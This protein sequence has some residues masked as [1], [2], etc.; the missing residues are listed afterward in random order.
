[1]HLK[2]LFQTLLQDLQYFF[3]HKSWLLPQITQA[4]PSGSSLTLSLLKALFISLISIASIASVLL[5]LF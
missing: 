4:S 3:F 5:F 2:L 1:M